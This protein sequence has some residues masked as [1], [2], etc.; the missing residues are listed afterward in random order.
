MLAVRIA[1]QVACQILQVY[2][3]KIDSVC[4]LLWAKFIYMYVH[5]CIAVCHISH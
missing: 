3:T 4:S 1:K 2:R 5:V